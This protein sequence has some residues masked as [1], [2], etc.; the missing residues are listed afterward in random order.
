LL[1]FY[2][3]PFT[4]FLPPTIPTPASATFRPRPHAPQDQRLLSSVLPGLLEFE[5][6]PPHEQQGDDVAEADLAR[7]RLAVESLE[8]VH[9]HLVVDGRPLPRLPG[10]DGALPETEGPFGR[11][12]P[13]FQAVILAD[14]L[15]FQ[16]E[17][18]AVILL[19]GLQGQARPAAF[20]RAGL[21]L[22]IDHIGPRL[23]GISA[24]SYSIGRSSGRSSHKSDTA[25][26]GTRPT[27]GLYRQGKLGRLTAF[28][29]RSAAGPGPAGPYPS[30]C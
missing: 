5:A 22:V 3:F 21:D 9:E 10:G 2:L 17:Q 12:L 19:A 26:P 4:F 15:A 8:A 30:R 14:Q 27:R 28:A 24:P 1:Y 13:G 7:L 16:V 11:P 20:P 23:R 18:D 25:G 6:A 29:V